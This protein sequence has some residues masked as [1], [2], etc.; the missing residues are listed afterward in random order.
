MVSQDLAAFISKEAQYSKRYVEGHED[1]DISSMAFHAPE[2]V[3][4]V[5]IAKS[6][7]FWEHPVKGEPRWKRIWQRENCRMQ[8]VPFEGKMLRLYLG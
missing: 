1:H 5:T 4:M 3:H 6:Q 2:P 7:R 8:Q